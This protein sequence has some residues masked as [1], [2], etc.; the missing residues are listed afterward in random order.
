MHAKLLQSC[1]TLCDPMDCSPP[2]SSAHGILQEERWSGLQCP[3]QGIF[4]TQGLNPYVMSPASVGGFFT[5]SATWEALSNAYKTLKDNF[6]WR[7]N[8]QC[9]CSH[10]K[11]ILFSQFERVL[12]FR[13]QSHLYDFYKE[14]WIIFRFKF[15]IVPCTFGYILFRK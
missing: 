7:H 11:W 12:K 4:L 10:W 8:E 15:N 1:L 2:G 3:P 13:T 6:F 14:I 5:T 9:Y